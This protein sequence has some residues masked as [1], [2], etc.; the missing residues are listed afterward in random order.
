MNINEW[1]D[2][3]PPRLLSLMLSQNYKTCIARRLGCFSTV[4]TDSH[5]ADIAGR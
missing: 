1:V 2:L 4:A 5:D 3:R